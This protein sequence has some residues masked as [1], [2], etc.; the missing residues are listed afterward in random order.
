MTGPSDLNLRH[1][2]ATAAIARRGSM[3]AAAD[4]VSLS[5]PAL[6][7]GLAKL[8]AQLGLPLFV[9][10]SD[11]MLP[12]PEGLILADRVE[13]AFHLLA[14][15]T[16]GPG[17]GFARPERLITSAQLRALVAL[18]DAGSFLGAAERTGL[19][20][21]AIHRS[22]RELEQIL[23]SPLAERKGRGV[24]LTA[25][26]RRVARGA[27]LAMG[28]IAAAIAELTDSPHTSGPILIG[29]MPLCRARLLPRAL[30]AFTRRFP[31]TRLTVIEGSWRELVE[32]LRE[33]GI[34]LMIGA[35]REQSAP[36]D[37]TEHALFDDRLVCVAGPGHPLA[38]TAKPS[39]E[40]LSA[41]PWIVGPSG[42]P[43]RAHWTA[44]FRDHV[45]P[46]APLECGSVMTIREILRESEFLTLLSPDQVEVEVSAGMLAHVGS[47]LPQCV[48][49]IGVTTRLSWRPTKAQAL[50]LELLESVAVEGRLHQS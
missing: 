6:T 35:L 13:R 39:L 41:Y 20:Q 49:T 28:E 10:R 46:Q 33:G 42:S 11:G 44:L 45:L 22:V 24:A 16:R 50:L 23:S 17:R 47:P 38:G 2:L 34:D 30:N 4:A 8:E 1:L 48:R 19:S 36:A 3:G 26:G 18:A 37:L 43:L 32:P 15:A 5:Q 25:V 21:P 29:A 9:R 31:D 40:Q 27:R 12:T 14:G 7:Q